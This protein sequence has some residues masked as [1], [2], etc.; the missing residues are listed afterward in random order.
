MKSLAFLLIS[1]LI[2]QFTC[3]QDASIPKEVENWIAQELKKANVQKLM[4]FQKDAF[5]RKDSVKRSSPF[6]FCIH[7][8]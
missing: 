2:A 5:F 3:A 8:R 1:I 7:Y 4:E 6:K